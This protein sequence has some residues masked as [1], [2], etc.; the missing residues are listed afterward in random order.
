[1]ASVSARALALAKQ[2]DPSL[3]I[4]PAVEDFDADTED[5]VRVNEL[6]RAEQR[7]QYF[8]YQRELVIAGLQILQDGS[9]GLISLPTGGG[10][11]RTAVGSV[12]EFMAADSSAS[13][14]WIAPTL[15]L[16]D[17]AHDTCVSLWQMHGS[18]GDI[19]LTRKAQKPSAGLVWFTTPQ[20]LSAVDSTEK[21]LGWAGVIFDEAHQIAAPTFSSA[22]ESVLSRNPSCGLLGLS[23]TPGRSASGEIEVLADMFSRNLLVSEIL[24][25][26]PVRFLQRRGVLSRLQFRAID[27][28]GMWVSPGLPRSTAAIETITEIANAGRQVLVFAQSVAESEALALVLTSA[29]ISASHVDGQISEYSRRNRINRFASRKTS[30]LI[31]QRLLSTGYDCPAVSDVVVIPRVSSAILFEQMVGRAARGPRT[32]GSGLSTIWQ[33]DDHLA[34]H[35]LPQSYYR[36][37]DYEWS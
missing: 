23:A 3:V 36:Y 31:N 8:D 10:K 15:E 26:N 19:E 20:G 35:G 2:I 4:V 18:V 1:M 25:S 29:G 34:I 37:K 22:T 6:R 11:T 12:L 7:P 28:T 13:V 30:V 32:G 21:L 27:D 5:R 33:F 14:I 24:G 17:Q 9:R 16:L